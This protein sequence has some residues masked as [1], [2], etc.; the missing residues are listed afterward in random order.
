MCYELL[1]HPSYGFCCAA[2]TFSIPVFH[3]HNPAGYRNVWYKQMKS[4]FKLLDGPVG[5]D[6]KISELEFFHNPI[7]PLTSF[8]LRDP[9]HPIYTLWVSYTLSACN[10]LCTHSMSLGSCSIV[11]LYVR[12][13][14]QLIL[15]LYFKFLVRN[16]ERSYAEIFPCYIAQVE[17]PC[18]SQKWQL[19][20]DYHF[21][22]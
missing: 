16:V 6:I 22:L 17:L 21:S 10:S 12:Y 9:Y 2:L 13:A 8:L 20:T 7:L 14:S 4:I 1:S 5:C 11:R 19:F 18:T 15:Y 3:V